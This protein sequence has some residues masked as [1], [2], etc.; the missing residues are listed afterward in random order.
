LFDIRY[1]NLF[2]PTGSVEKN[3]YC[4]MIDTKPDLKTC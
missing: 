1:S 2:A 4:E 3:R